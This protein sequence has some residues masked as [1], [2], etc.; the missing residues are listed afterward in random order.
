MRSSVKT[1]IVAAALCV[2]AVIAWYGWFNKASTQTAP[3][4]PRVQ[5][6]KTTLSQQQSLP[7]T[8]QANGYV[9]PL[10]TVDVRAQVQSIVQSIHVREGQ[11][12]QAG[13][14]LF[15]L[16]DRSAVSAVAKA[17]AEL[18][19]NQS[20]LNDAELTLKRQ[21]DLLAQNFV[22][23][24]AVDTARMKVDALRGS[25]A[26]AKATLQSEQ[27]ALSYYKIRA[28]MSGRI[29]AINVHVGSL[30]QP[31]GDALVKIVQIHPIAVAFSVPERELPFIVTSYP[32][33]DAPVTVTLA[34]QSRVEG[35]LFFVD[36]ASDAQSG[37]I[38][39]KAQFQNAN[40][41]LWPGTYVTVQMVA[42]DLKDVIVVPVQSVISG[43]EEKFVYVVGEGQVARQQVVKVLAI[44]QGLAAVTGLAAGVPVVVDGAQNLR[45]G[46]VVKEK[47]DQPRETDV[48]N[49][50]KTP[51]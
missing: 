28:S 8:V 41:R 30:A 26:A 14:L 29:G 37:T 9:T 12:V 50:V 15:T 32:K 21:V 3:T 11:F 48:T 46:S 16:D 18:A 5:Y 35:Q 20:D 38:K 13:D 23:P 1:S 31:S 22:S 36:N 6:V 24:S 19:S 42:R 27:V 43:P 7:I 33:L 25:V 44:E 47:A 10:N 34:D 4:G 17:Q 49:A 45:P 2:V 39:M 51:A 40:S